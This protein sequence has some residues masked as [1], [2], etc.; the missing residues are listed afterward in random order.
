MTKYNKGVA[1]AAVTV[2]AWV[3]SLFG[4]DVPAQVQGA[5]ITIAV[6]F[7]PNR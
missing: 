7:V 6:V 2:A 1:A 4:V 5:L 3:A